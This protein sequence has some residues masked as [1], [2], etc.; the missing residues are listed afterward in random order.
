MAMVHHSDHELLGNAN[1]G[2]LIFEL[3][4]VVRLG[5]TRLAVGLVKY[6]AEA[7]ALIPMS[8]GM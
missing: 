3:D 1:F 7:R 5:R 8:S 6:I 4:K 2:M